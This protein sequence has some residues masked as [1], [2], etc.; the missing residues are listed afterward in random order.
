MSALGLGAGGGG[1][2]GAGWPTRPTPM[3]ARPD[4]GCVIC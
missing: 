4:A 3:R 1:G 2:V